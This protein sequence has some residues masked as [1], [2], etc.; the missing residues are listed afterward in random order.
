[1]ND[2]ENTKLNTASAEFFIWV[3]FILA[4]FWIIS[5]SFQDYGSPLSKLI[6]FSLLFI[7]LALI[8]CFNKKFNLKNVSPSSLNIASG[9][10]ILF[11][12]AILFSFVPKYLPEISNP[13]KVDVGYDTYDAL[14]SLLNKNDPYK[15]LKIGAIGQDSR[16]WGYHYGSIMLLFYAPSLLF[17]TSSGIKFMNLYY[18]IALVILISCL[19]YNKNNSKSANIFFISFSILVLLLPE[20]LWYE[21]FIS[22]T[23][24]IFPLL[25]LL[26]SIP[27][28]IKKSWFLSGLL[29]GLSISSKFAP[30]L[31]FAFLLIRK[32][33]NFSLF[34]GLFAGILPVIL[35]LLLSSNAYNS[36]IIFHMVKPFDSSS[37]YSL[38]PSEF[39]FIF[40]LI[41]ILSLILFILIDFKKDIDEKSLIFSFAFLLIIIELSYK[42]LHANH[43]LWFFPLIA[44]IFGAYIFQNK[45]ELNSPVSHKYNE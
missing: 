2:L 13:A 30:A 38:V 6:L 12:V 36:M 7:L 34:Y 5:K 18:L 33:I 42:E 27:F 19:V 9:V 29:I 25:L 24:D 23:T 16:L 37:L 21:S 43:L 44:Y 14:K 17:Y 15:N 39:H 32:K 20:K 22:G 41:A 4:S 26:L 31:F 28:I 10:V 45:Q 35:T 11:I 1:M 3:F 8:Y 40:P